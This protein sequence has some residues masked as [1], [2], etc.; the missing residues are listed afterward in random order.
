MLFE[1]VIKINAEYKGIHL[2]RRQLLF[3]EFYKRVNLCRTWRGDT[4]T[5]HGKKVFLCGLR[6]C[7]ERR[8]EGDD[9]GKK[10][11]SIF[12]SG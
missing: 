9:D 4:K 5:T 1:L 2:A 11:Y 7:L 10:S 12:H 6:P 3:N 8:E